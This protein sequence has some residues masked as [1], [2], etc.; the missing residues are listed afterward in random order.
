[1]ESNKNHDSLAEG[2]SKKLMLAVKLLHSANLNSHNFLFFS[3]QVLF[4]KRNIFVS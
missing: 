4:Y 1:M 2:I 3:F